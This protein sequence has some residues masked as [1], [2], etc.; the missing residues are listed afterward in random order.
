MK[1]AMVIVIAAL[2]WVAAAQVT[3][4][5]M[6]KGEAG[7]EKELRAGRLSK[8]AMVKRGRKLSFWQKLRLYAYSRELRPFFKPLEL[9]IRNLA[10]C[11]PEDG[12]A[13]QS[14]RRQ[15]A[16]A[17]AAARRGL[18]VAKRASQAQDWRRGLAGIVFLDQDWRDRVR[19]RNNGEIKNPFDLVA[20]LDCLD[21]R[22]RG[23]G[24]GGAPCPARAGR[25]VPGGAR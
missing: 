20:L 22:Q 1:S 2:G 6:V 3:G 14:A 7:L 19:R 5:E 10:R 9:A 23:L 25:P 8:S 13:L 16:Q 12:P 4:G 18:R 15:V 17:L 21:A 24:A 11:S